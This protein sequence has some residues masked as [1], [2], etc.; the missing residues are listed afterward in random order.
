MER[1]KQLRMKNSNPNSERSKKKAEKEFEFCKVC[2]LNHNQ[3]RKHNFFPYHKKS[4]SSFLSN[5][6]PKISDVRFFLKNPTLLRPEFASRNRFWCVF[7]D[8]VIDELGSEFACCYSINHLA[9]E[10][11]LKSLKHFLWK[12][13]GGMDRVDSFRISQAD[14]VKWEKRCTLLKNREAEGSHGPVNNIQNKLIYDDIHDFVKSNVDS[15]EHSFS[16][17]VLPLQYYTNERSQ[18][19]DPDFYDVGCHSHQHHVDSAVHASPYSNMGSW[20]LQNLTDISFHYSWP[21]G[22]QN[23]THISLPSQEANGNVHTGACPPWLKA[24]EVNQLNT[25]VNP[26]SGI[27]RLDTSLNKSQKSQKLNP[28]RV[29]AAWAERRKLELEMEKRG[30]IVSTCGDDWLP[31]FGRVWQSGTRKESRKEF[32]KGKQKAT[33][34]ADQSE[35]SIEIQP[36]ISK[37]MVI[38]LPSLTPELVV[39]VS[40]SVMMHLLIFGSYDH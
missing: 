35:V 16:H 5:F 19:S 17:D 24:I 36:Y 6:L 27:K 21:S 28:K 15:V 2:K 10:E 11:H 40:K 34:V 29:G 9:S 39:L 26:G 18:V 31:N 37:R 12:Y 32:E 14:V 1:E 22:L 25:L 13:G 30:E 8:S 23:L 20:G 3:G 7:C 33:Q 38:L 4:L